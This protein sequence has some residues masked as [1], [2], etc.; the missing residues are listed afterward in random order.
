MAVLCGMPTIQYLDESSPLYVHKLLTSCIRQCLVSRACDWVMSALSAMLLIFIFKFSL[1]FFHIG[2]QAT[3]WFALYQTSN[4]AENLGS[5]FLVHCVWFWIDANG[6]MELDIP[7]RTILVVSFRLSVIIVELWRPEVARRW[8]LLMNFCVFLNDPLQRNFQNSVQKVF[9][10]SPIDVV[11]FKFCEILPT[12][13]QRNRALFNGQRSKI[14]AASQTVAT[15]QVAL[16]FRRG[17][18]PIIYSKCSRFHPNRFTF[19]GVIA[20][21]V[22][23]AKLPRRENPIFGGSLASSR[24]TRQTM[25]AEWMNVW[26]TSAAERSLLTDD[27]KFPCLL[28][29]MIVN[30][31]FSDSALDSSTRINEYW[32]IDWLIGWHVHHLSSMLV[33]RWA[34]CY[35]F[36]NK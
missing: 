25:R 31:L 29:M 30:P 32:L 17:Q 9:T 18:L 35:L 34:L 27:V 2:R 22:Y 20:K 12:E 3:Q 28:S 26:Q 14:S 1:L 10:A 19:G 11:V 16:K 33:A 36:L 6:K 8:N 21:R 13:N 24:I 5:T 4:V 23:I 15:A 7:Q